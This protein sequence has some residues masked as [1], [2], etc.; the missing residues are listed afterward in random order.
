MTFNTTTMRFFVLQFLNKHKPLL[1]TCMSVL[2]MIY[3]VQS[4][5]HD[6]YL[7]VDEGLCTSPTLLGMEFIAPAANTGSGTY[8][9]TWWEESTGSGY[10]KRE[11][12]SS[13]GYSVIKDQYTPPSSL[14]GGYVYVS[15]KMPDGC[16]TVRKR[17]DIQ[18][19]TV[20]SVSYTAWSCSNN[21]V[22]LDVSGGTT[23]QVRKDGNITTSEASEFSFDDPAPFSSYQVRVGNGTCYSDWTSVTVGTNLSV[24]TPSLS[25]VGQFCEGASPS[26]VKVRAD[27]GGVSNQQIGIYHWYYTNGNEITNHYNN[28]IDLPFD[29]NGYL[30]RVKGIDANS[31]FCFSE[32]VSLSIAGEQMTSAGSLTMGDKEVCY[33][34]SPGEITASTPVGGID[35][36]YQW[37]VSSDGSSWSDIAGGTGASYTPGAL[38]STTY[39]RRKVTACG[40]T[41]YTGS[42]KMTVRDY[43]IYL[44]AREL[45]CTSPTQLEA[46]FIVPAAG[47]G[48]GNYI[49]TWYSSPTG[50]ANE[51]RDNI[52]HTSSSEIITVSH[53]ASSALYGQSLWVSIETP[54]GCE[55]TRQQLDINEYSVPT[56]TY[57]AWTCNDSQVSIYLIGGTEKEVRVNGST[58]NDTQTNFS[59]D[60]APPYDAYEVRVGENGCYSSWQTVSIGANLDVDLPSSVIVDPYCEASPPANITVTMSGGGVPDPSYTQYNWYDMSGTPITDHYN[61]VFSLPYDVTGYQYEVYSV[62]QSS[63]HACTSTRQNLTILGSQLT[64]AGTISDVEIITCYNQSPGE[65]T[66][67]T[68]VG[69]ID[70]VYQWQ[71]SSDGSSWSDIAG[72]TGASYTPG[73][74]VSTTYFRRKVTACGTT[75]YTGR[76]KMT[77]RDYGIY[78]EARELTCTSPTQLEAEFIV[79]AAG[80]GTGN[81]II[82]WYSSPTG[83]ANE[84]RDNINHTSSSE[85]ITVSHEASSALYGQSL[86]VSIETPGGCET[87][88]QQLDIN[89]Y[90][91]PTHTYDAWTCNDSQVS[92]YLIGGTEKE[93]RVNGS[94][95]ND[96]QTNFSFDDAP[97]YDAYEVRVGENGCYSSWQT[98]SI[99]ANL[100]VDLPSSVIVDPY[101]EA[102]PPA[103]ITVTM[104][105][106]GVP[107]PSYTQYNWYDM[108][109]TPITDH[110]NPV[111]SLPYDV[112]GYQYEVYSVDQSSGHACTSTRQNLTIL[113]SQLTDAGTIS[114]VEIITCYNQ[115]PGEITASTPVG[116]IDHV[117]QWQVSSDG[118]SWSDIAGGTGASYTPGALVST[119]YFRRKVTACGTTLYTGRVKMT[120]RD[121]GIYLEARELTCTSPTQ[122][123]AEFIVPAAGTGTGNYIITWYS[124]PTGTANEWRDNIN[125]TSSS[126][127]I[128]VSHEASSALYGQSLWVSIETPG[129]CETTRQ[130]LDI[131]EYSVPTHTY[132]AWTC[133]DSQVSIYLIGGTEKEVRVNGSTYND[134]QTNFFL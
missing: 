90:S 100:D 85:I 40:T 125:H 58:Y 4:G 68:P 123:E 118:S 28:E 115:S 35:H 77:V 33:N 17:L 103:N 5:C 55:T 106:G 95:Y 73:A 30:C 88:R 7:I 31:R 18:E 23:K 114:D 112:T 64:D 133:N 66:A 74:L 104:S 25:Q 87:T 79:P 120:V 117:Y 56:H 92:I 96:T 91:V 44:E 8:T 36:V 107:D 24:S 122:L 6:N 61:P 53:E 78:L 127:I 98:V 52:N 89:E 93:V 129:G 50:T 21:Q 80:T 121:Y 69:G 57:D 94:T 126:E 130:Q 116:G 101:C 32:Q 128:T 62:D 81:Y 111:F 83:T 43:S 60:D 99:G 48:T 119:T 12:L 105:G 41:L 45:T 82:T 132:D 131:N 70:H 49:I 72:G 29:Q 27:G 47:T 34:Q 134:T 19:Y 38:V 26:T 1:L 113:G 76:V 63:G 15:V 124:S 54:G 109:G 16:E 37:Q 22:N 3:D 11:Y 10:R 97:P 59:F 67:S 65:I 20:P 51:W 39:F 71:V 42:V 102:S 9:V 46:E 14:Y 108:S 86:W 84:W 13:D 2:L 110:Y 75:L